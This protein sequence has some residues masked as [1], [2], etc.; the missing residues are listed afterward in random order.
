MDI[1][2]PMNTSIAGITNITGIFPAN[3]RTIYA[4]IL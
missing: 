4:Y 1:R 3:I 2:I